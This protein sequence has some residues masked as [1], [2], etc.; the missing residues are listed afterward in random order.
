MKHENT[1][2]RQSNP[3]D[4][5]DGLFRTGSETTLRDVIAPLFRHRNLVIFC[6]FG[7]L[8]IG[9]GVVLL[10]PAQFK[11]HMQVLVKRA[12]TDPV[13]TSEQVPQTV[14]QTTPPVTEEEIN[15]E[16]QLLETEDLLRHVV[17]ATDLNA[18]K[19][20]AWLSFLPARNE[21]QRIAEA[22]KQLAK[23]LNVAAVKNTNVIDVT[24]TAGNPQVAYRV[25]TTLGNLY[26][27]KHLAVYRPPGALKFFQQQT[28]RYGKSLKRAEARLAAFE[29]ANQVDSTQLQ[30]DLTQR[31]LSN[32]DQSYRHTQME[33]S[34]T[35]HRIGEL[36]S[37]LK[38]TPARL[39]TAQ[40]V[41][42][43]SQLLQALGSTLATLQ[44]KRT[45]MADNYQPDYRPYQE[46]RAQIARAH[47]QIRA[48]KHS[49]LQA[50]TTDVNPTYLWLTE[51]LAKSR[52][53][54]ATYKAKA[55]ATDRNVDLYRG[56]L[57][58]LGREEIEQA[59]LIRNTKSDERNYLLYLNRR[60][61]ARI[62]DALD[63]RRIL[64]VSI[65]EP[66]SVP[67]FPVNSRGRSFLVVLASAALI[68]LATGFV[69]DFLD[70]TLRTADETAQVLEI[71]VLA[72]MPKVSRD[73]SSVA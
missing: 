59:D 62:S 28:E 19:H 40:Q 71:P 48:A 37:Q 56:T 5:Q 18:R 70:P 20:A 21:D 42:D 63:S 9:V 58:Q 15:S 68:G 57:G 51:E 72:A 41:S 30:S 53:D 12:R 73:R 24:Y 11:A 26:L 65:A 33:I 14:Q 55:A 2:S 27:E 66:P 25:L 1:E 35:K 31:T 34:A 36:E 13:V 69:A 39:N 3:E 60:E 45:E 64:N 61:E 49:P 23:H 17:L 44:L 50:D 7:T 46:L 10:S 67:V 8:L 43:N 32:L 47:Q 16:V 22:V 29:R 4:T 54:L 38:T 6:F 52:T